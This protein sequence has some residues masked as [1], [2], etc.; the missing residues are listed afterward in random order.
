M[1]LTQV[2]KILVNLAHSRIEWNKA[3]ELI[4]SGDTFIGYEVTARL[5]NAEADYPHVIEGKKDGKYR[6]RRLRIEST[7]DWLPTLPAALRER[8]EQELQATGKHYKKTITRYVET[9]Q[10]EMRKVT[11]TI[12]L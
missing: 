11:E 12:E 10:R 3:H 5:S 1:K 9:P 6:V 4:G 8:I 2:E 7:Q